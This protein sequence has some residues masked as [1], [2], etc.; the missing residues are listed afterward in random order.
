MLELI[1]VV[2]RYALCMDRILVLNHVD[3]APTLLKWLHPGCVSEGRSVFEC[4]FEP[5]SG[6]TLTAEEISAAPAP[7]RD[8]F[9][10]HSYPLRQERILVLRGMPWEGDC[11]VC[12]SPWRADSRFFDG[13]HMGFTFNGSAA[14]EHIHHAAAFTGA[15][16][17]TWAAQFLRYLLRPRPWF[18]ETL[19]QIIHYSMQSPAFAAAN[20]EVENDGVEDVLHDIS[21][22]GNT[23][24]LSQLLPTSAF[25]RRRFL[26]LHVRFGMKA[27][28][29]ALQPLPRYMELLARKL[30]YLT[31]IFIS[32]ETEAVIATLAL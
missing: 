3:Q 19:A 12:H 18:A 30:P 10:F 11:S 26:S 24:E 14:A 31:D 16:K 25:P 28:E 21:G 22:R 8:G 5:V 17:Q 1:A 29:V 20:V 6:C 23:A 9:G 32:T 15:V 4:Y 7:S 27:A 13:L 2:F